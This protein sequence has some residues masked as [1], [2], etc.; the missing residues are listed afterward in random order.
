MKN[1]QEDRRAITASTRTSTKSFGQFVW[2]FTF[3]HTLPMS[4]VSTVNLYVLPG[5]N[6]DR[7]G[8]AGLSIILLV[9]PF[10]PNS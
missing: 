9:S 7:E 10:S 3:N 8:P 4:T 5:S 1:R 2:C 6:F